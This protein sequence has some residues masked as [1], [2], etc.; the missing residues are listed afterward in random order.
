MLIII[1]GRPVP[2]VRMTGRGKFIKPAAARY[3][4]YKEQIGWMALSQTQRPII[5]PVT[6][7]VKVFLHGV[8]TPMGLDGDIDNYLKSALDGCNKVAWID[9]R[10]VQKAT[11]EKIPCQHEKQERMEIE[12]WEVE[13]P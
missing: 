7:N 5:N 3:L 2:A 6:V 8:S 12:I 13:S 4:A 10:Q 1:T 9:D 11:V